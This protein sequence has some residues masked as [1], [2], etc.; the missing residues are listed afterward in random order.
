MVECL[1]GIWSASGRHLVGS[2]H[3]LAQLWNSAQWGGQNRRGRRQSHR[4]QAAFGS[5][6]G[7]ERWDRLATP[8]TIFEKRALFEQLDLFTSSLNVPSYPHLN[9]PQLSSI[10][11]LCPEICSMPSLM[12]SPEIAPPGV[13]VRS[14]VHWNRAGA[15]PQGTNGTLTILTCNDPIPMAPMAQS[16]IDPCVVTYTWHTLSVSRLS[17]SQA[18]GECI[19]FDQLALRSPLGKVPMLTVATA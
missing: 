8:I 18:G 2:W 16:C 1:V 11:K 17:R 13:C 10:A 7:R 3:N 6:S 12:K 5:S 15:H 9:L 19:T 4:W 14:A